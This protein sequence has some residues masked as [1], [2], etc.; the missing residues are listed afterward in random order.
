[1]IVMALSNSPI[2][3]GTSLHCLAY[4]TTSELAGRLLDYVVRFTPRTFSAVPVDLVS[5]GWRC[6]GL[7]AGVEYACAC[8]LA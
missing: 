3:T 5:D 6:Q 4:R 2:V 7:L 1:M 8:G